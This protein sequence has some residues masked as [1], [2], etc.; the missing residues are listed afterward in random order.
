M[1]GAMSVVLFGS[2]SGSVTL[3]EPA[4]AGTTVLD[5]PATTGT[6]ALLQ[7]P[8]FATTIGVGGATAA[9]SGAGITFPAS[10]SASSDANTLDDYEE[11]TFTPTLFGDSTAGSATYGEQIG[12][13]TKIGRQVTV[14]VL[15]GVSAFT[16][17]GVM[18]LGNFP[19]TSN[20][21]YGQGVA[22][23]MVDS[24][25]WIGGTYLVGYIASATNSI[26]VFTCTD[27]SGWAAQTCVNEDQT[28]YFTLTYFV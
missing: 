10:Q 3:Q 22:P 28:F 23:I 5:L 14:T 17:T 13:Y 24:L 2:T 19:F 20:S 6:M 21:S 11:G 26:R 8:S 4:V 7:T 18:R 12:S 16:G 9:A 25:N 27:D 15:I 1:G